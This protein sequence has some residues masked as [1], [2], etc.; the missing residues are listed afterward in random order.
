M[1]KKLNIVQ[2]AGI[3]NKSIEFSEGL[4]V[5]VGRNEAGKSSAMEALYASLFTSTRIGNKKVEDKR[6]AEMAFPYESGD[7]AE[8][9]ITFESDGLEYTLHKLWHSS[10]SKVSLEKEGTRIMDQSAIEDIMKAYLVYG[11]G[12]YLNVMFSKQEAFKALFEAIKINPETIQT[13]GQLLKN[14]S[15]NLDG[16]SIEAYK[17]RLENEYKTL[18]SNWD[19]EKE[20]PANNK[21]WQNPH[22][23][24]VGRILAHHYEAEKAAYEAKFTEEREME[25]E[26]VQAEIKVFIEDKTKLVERLNA[27]AS[28]EADVIRHQTLRGKLDQIEHQNKE[29]LEVNKKWP[30]VEA[31][32]ANAEENI[33]KS[34]VKLAGVQEKLK[35]VKAYEKFMYEY[36]SFEKIRNMNKEIEKKKS[37]LKVF[38]KVTKDEVSRLEG[39]EKAINS[40]EVKLKSAELAGHLLKSSQPAIVTDVYGNSIK[41]PIGEI[42]TT[43]AYMKIEVG[44]EFTLEV[45]SNQ[46]D[47]T[48]VK[49]EFKESSSAFEEKLIELGATSIEDAKLKNAHAREIEIKLTNIEKQLKEMPVLPEDIDFDAKKKVYDRLPLQSIE[50]LEEAIKEIQNEIKGYEHIKTQCDFQLKQWKEKFFSHDDVAITLGDN[51]SEKKKLN[52]ELSELSELPEEFS[53]VEEYLSEIRNTQ[54]LRDEL[55]EKINRLEIAAERVLS[56]LP[57]R[58][59]EEFYESHEDE[60]QKMNQLIKKAKQLDIITR[61]LEQ[62]MEQFKQDSYSNLERSFMSNLSIITKNKYDVIDLNDQLDV[63]IGCK[64]KM[65]PTK[66]LSSGTLDSVAL[67]FRLAIIDELGGKNQKLT[68]LDDCLVNMDEDRQAKAIEMIK[69]HARRHQVIFVTCHNWVAEMLGGNIIEM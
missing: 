1:I 55:S 20:K 24:R 36:Q 5:I 19:M 42:W 4:N 41:V 38:S 7:H 56:E 61:K 12:T 31:D 60:T 51:L 57:E 48:K 21:S 3:N 50:T 68:V 28:I 25:L 67:A 26:K 44:D 10:D 17:D 34:Q 9:S 35:T 2:F 69:E 45:Q 52:S 27:I 23:N 46:I 39:L 63:A 22:K 33:Q 11:E 16:L 64:D 65:L 29:L 66:L 14:A 40:A 13:I 18:T 32:Q 62:I 58:S 47:F 59:S 37:E 43:N 15:M 30:A 49:E 6:F 53:T 8:C 54:R